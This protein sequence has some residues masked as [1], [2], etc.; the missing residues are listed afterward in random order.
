MFF[1][2][3]K[4]GL[5][6]NIRVNESIHHAVDAMKLPDTVPGDAPQTITLLPPCLTFFWVYLGLFASPFFL[7]HHSQSS[8]PK[9]LNLDSSE[10]MTAHQSSAVQ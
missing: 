10:N 7:Q 9:I 6:K 1:E 2:S 5:G 3:A 8:E 4:K